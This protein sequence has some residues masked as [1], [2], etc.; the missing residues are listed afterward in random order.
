M[1]QHYA[2]INVTKVRTEKEV[3]DGVIIQ[4]EIYT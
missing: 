3:E 4:K 1:V 2:K